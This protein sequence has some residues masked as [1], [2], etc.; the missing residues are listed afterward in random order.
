VRCLGILLTVG[1]LLITCGVGAEPK[2]SGIIEIDLRDQVRLEG[3]TFTLGDIA[4]LD[5]MDSRL[6]SRLKRVLLSRTPRAGV[7]AQ[8]DRV[9]VASRIDRLLPGVSKRV[10]WKGATQTRVQARYRRFGRQGYL[11]SAQHYLE[12]WLGERFEDF[13]AKPV[14]SYEDLELP[15]GNVTMRA[16][17]A[18]RDRLSKRMCV[19]IDLMIDEAHF[20]TL[21]VW[22]D[23]TAY[24]EVFELQR[25]LSAGTQLKPEMLMKAKHD[26][27][28]VSG[29]PVVVLAAI[30][31]QRLIRDLP[32][33][34][35]LTE[36]VLQSVPDVVK[37]QKLQVKASVGRV[38]LIALARALQ[39]G[40][41]GDP[42]R[43]EKLDGSDKYM[44]RVLDTGLAVVEEDYQ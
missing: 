15:T 35:V 25:D 14:G 39:D 19:W 28:T 17:V 16:E 12:N 38:T 2:L 37:G 34:S 8:I 20:N 36:T 11:D 9:D 41:R 23:V 3:R 33:G 1:L 43:V 6:V 10:V 7:S 32:G 40:N 29:E 44:A 21:P 22:F 4:K 5:G 18:H 31:G 30:D 42:I 26:L 27:A 24:A 13:V